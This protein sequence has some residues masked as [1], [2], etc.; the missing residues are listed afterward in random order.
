MRTLLRP[1]HCR[2]AK[3]ICLG[4]MV[5]AFVAPQTSFAQQAIALEN[6]SFEE[7]G[8]EQTDFANVPGW[9][10]EVTPDDS[11]VGMNNYATDGSWAAWLASQDPALWQLTDYVIQEGDE[12]TL[13]VDIR[14]SWNT[15]GVELVL[16]YDDNGER[17]DVAFVTHS[18]EGESD[19][20]MA[21]Y[22]ATLDVADAPE[23]VGHQLGVA[24]NNVS[25]DGA[26]IELDNV[27]LTNATASSVEESMAG[28]FVLEQNAPNP[29]RTETSIAYELDQPGIVVLDVFDLLGHKVQTL[30]HG[31][32]AAGTHGVRWNA[33]NA[34]GN[35]APSGM[36]IYRLTVQPDGAGAASSLTKRMLLVR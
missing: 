29:F 33:Q 26:Y 11:G 1:L 27:R 22:T 21:E 4:L 36:Y 2:I 23:A 7:P 15:T 19:D 34:A 6:P 5:V 28:Q 20:A 18:F 8:S 17:M 35:P 25:A 32:V 30:V 10:M 16:Y 9:S 31:R 13:A 24:I 12:I 14:N 3:A